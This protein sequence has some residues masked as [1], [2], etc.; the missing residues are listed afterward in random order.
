M[1]DNLGRRSM[2]GL[3]IGNL[4]SEIPAGLIN[5]FLIP[6]LLFSIKSIGLPIMFGL[7][8]IAVGMLL[9]PKLTNIF[10]KFSFGQR[11]GPQ[12]LLYSIG[13]VM[14]LIS[15]NFLFTPMNSNDLEFGKT[16]YYT[17]LL[18]IYNIAWSFAIQPITNSIQELVPV[19]TTR[20]W[21]HAHR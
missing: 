6:F 19:Q 15:F 10:S 12:K 8:S 2:W 5:A 17:I 11:F 21:I 13:T 9:V 4:V 18:C 14:L 7:I 16:V 20:M 3:L 1:E